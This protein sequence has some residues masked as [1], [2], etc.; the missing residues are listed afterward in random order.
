MWSLSFRD[1]TQRITEAFD[2]SNVLKNGPE[3]WV[4]ILLPHTRLL[5]TSS[6]RGSV[7]C[8]TGLN[9]SPSPGNNWFHISTIWPFYY[10][11][12]A[13]FL[14]EESSNCNSFL[15][16]L[17]FPFLFIHGDL[18]ATLK[19]RTAVRMWADASSA[20]LARSLDQRQVDQ[21]RVQAPLRKEHAGAQRWWW[22]IKI[23]L[24][25]NEIAAG[26]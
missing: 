17:K 8:A 9:F 7:T 2:R 21:L 24:K 4:C 12:L 25:Q 3:L 11:S 10:K 6:H 26:R 1:R 5:W 22:K 20:L 18:I 14:S 16:L 15:P 19:E 23:S 13:F